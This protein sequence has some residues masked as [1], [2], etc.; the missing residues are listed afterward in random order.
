M[1]DWIGSYEI[2][3]FAFR[4]VRCS[5][6]DKQ[7]EDAR[8]DSTPPPAFSCT[9]LFNYYNVVL[10]NKLLT[11]ITTSAKYKKILY[12]TSRVALIRNF[13]HDLIRNI[14][15]CQNLILN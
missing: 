11:I 1:V 8:Q 14:G 6:L 13:E 15:P 9:Y 10:F 2:H 3:F 5:L 7:A 4:F 12:Q